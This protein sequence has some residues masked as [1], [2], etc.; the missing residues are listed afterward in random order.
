MSDPRKTQ[1]TQPT[2]I[3]R[4]SRTQE[5]IDLAGGSL[6]QAGKKYAIQSGQITHFD[7]QTNEA[8]GDLTL[9]AT[10]RFSLLNGR[11]KIRIH[12]LEF[13]VQMLKS[14]VAPT[15]G[16]V[17]LRFMAWLRPSIKAIKHDIDALRELVQG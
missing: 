10:S 8:R 9:L 14:I 2:R 5:L 11:I 4:S 15:R 1:L 12:Q 16:E 3:L 13:E 6:E 17:S 7:E